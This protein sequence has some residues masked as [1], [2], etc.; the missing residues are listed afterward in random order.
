MLCEH[1][2][3][4]RSAFT[5]FFHRWNVVLVSRSKLLRLSEWIFFQAE[6]AEMVVPGQGWGEAEA[7]TLAVF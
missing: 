6:S 4:F 7:E 5:V 1:F 3:N 2:F